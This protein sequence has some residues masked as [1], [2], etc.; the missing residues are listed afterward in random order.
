MYFVDTET[1]GLHGFA[2]IIQ[3]AL[4]DGPI[5]IHEVWRTPIR[6]TLE[7]IDKIAEEGICGFNLAFDWFH[8]CKIYTTFI[9]VEDK[10]QYPEDMIN[11]IAILEQKARFGKCLKPKL[12]LDLMLHARKGEFQSL[13]ARDEI[14]IRR[15]PTAMAALL[16]QELQERVKIDDIY[17]ANK[18][19]KFAPR[20]KAYPAKHTDDFH[21]VVLKFAPSR[22]LKTLAKYALGVSETI[23][24]DDAGV[25]K[26]L[27]PVECGYAPFALAT[28]TVD[29]SWRVMEKGKLQGFAWPGVIDQHIGHWAYHETGRQ[30][31]QDDV[32]YTRRLW[33]YF[34]CPNANDDDSVLSCAVA[35]IRWSG[36]DINVPGLIACREAALLV[37]K[38]SPKAPAKVKEYLSAAM[39]E[40]EQLAILDST[41]RTVLEAISRW[42][43]TN[44][45]GSVSQ[46]PAAKRASEVL[47]AR[48]AQKEIELYDK[49]IHAGRFHASFVIIGTLSNRMSGSD[50]L[51]PQGINHSKFVRVNFTFCDNIDYILSGGDFSSFEIA[52]ADA[53]YADP[54]MHNDLV[55]GIKLH[56]VMGA[57]LYDKTIEEVL[58]S[59]G[60][61]EID[62]YNTGKKG[63]FLLIYGGNE[64]TFKNKLG[65]AVEKGLEAFKRFFARYP[66]FGRKRMEKMKDYCSMAQPNGIGTAV[67]WNEPKQYAE[68]LYGFRRFFT[69]ETKICR[70]LFE[71]A[72]T[73]PKAW[74]QI[75]VKV[76]R[77]E[78]I[79]TAS[80]AT[81][82]ALY[83]AAFGMQGANMRAALNHEIQSSGATVAKKVERAIWDIQP[84][85][86]NDFI[87]KPINIHDE[88]IGPVKKSYESQVKERVD[89]EI[90]DNRA[91]IPLLKMNWKIGLK[92]WSEKK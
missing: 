63:N 60:S 47:A 14:R 66:V 43:I 78:R 76:Q 86:F 88:I 30:Y 20:W 19:D 53:V 24:Y 31:A 61:K 35:A 71:L 28:S 15:I 84:H 32:D 2:I 8:L 59:E 46:H 37:V 29:K 5:I 12:A 6:E 34:G 73:P 18:K 10:E 13:M 27:Y 79:Q 92:N 40:T 69:L 90:A 62:M 11:E 41:K 39:D 57:A 48:K 3:Y 17:F 58:A 1:C 49:L 9:L 75:K 45:D 56:A 50:G 68:S 85:G 52:I 44:A 72:Q 64:S 33:H 65:I 42:T 70:V 91:K 54:T 83:A 36:F 7:L 80:G 74:K 51:N 38:R 26:N 16:C 89:K 77:R 82:S 21:D 87:V 55:S 25:D 67:V 22:S 81:Q 4:N 23:L